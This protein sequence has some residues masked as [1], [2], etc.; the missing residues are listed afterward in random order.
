MATVRLVPF[1]IVVDLSHSELTHI[2]NHLSTGAATAASVVAILAAF[3][4]TGP[5]GIA[6][7]VL[8]ALLWL[9]ASLL[10][11]CDSNQ[12]GIH[13]IVLWVGAPWCSSQ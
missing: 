3:G 8:G 10:T 2:T 12:K 7:G 11:Q 5:T 9:G 4:I 6:A 13:L 1:G